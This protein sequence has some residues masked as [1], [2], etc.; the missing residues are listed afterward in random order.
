MDFAEQR[1]VSTGLLLAETYHVFHFRG[2][3]PCLPGD[4]HV[5]CMLMQGDDSSPM[6]TGYT[7]PLKLGPAKS[8]LLPAAPAPSVQLLSDSSRFNSN[9]S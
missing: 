9:L 8:E 6:N 1:G 2:K 5:W 4:C 7:E 3:C